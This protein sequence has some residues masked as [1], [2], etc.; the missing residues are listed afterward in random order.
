MLQR[1]GFDLVIINVERIL[2]H[3][4]MNGIEPLARLV[5]R[6]TVRQVPTRIQRHAK[7][8]VTWLQKRLK[9]TLVGLATRI[10]LNVGKAAVKQLAGPLNRKVF[11]LVHK[12]TPTVIAPSGIAFGVFVRHHR[13]LRLHDGLRDDIFRGNQLNL[14]PLTAK[15]AA[16]GAKNLCVGV[17][18][19]G[20]E[21]TSVT[22]GCIHIR[23]SV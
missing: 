20:G 21:E 11:G 6:S 5:R 10:R 19:V 7:D 9:H 18:K 13:T 12:L 17:G 4:I 8:R 22:V 16:D 1:Q 3:A 14:V 23:V 2:P 15:F